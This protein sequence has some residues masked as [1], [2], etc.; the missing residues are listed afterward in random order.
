MANSIEQY[1]SS[2]SLWKNQTSLKNI[3]LD[4]ASNTVGATQL[5]TNSAG[6]DVIIN[7]TAPTASGQV[8]VTTSTTNATW[9]TFPDATNFSDSTFYVYNNTTNTKKLN[10]SLSGATASTT[11][12]L[13][14]VQ[15]TNRTIT[16]PDISD[17]VVTLTQINR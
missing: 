7:T 10:I 2:S 14:G 5:M 8:L 13:A 15:T 12:S 1:D 17:T 3:T 6:N 16:F 9:Q 11:L 4:D